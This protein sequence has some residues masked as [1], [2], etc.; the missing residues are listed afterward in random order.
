MVSG[1]EQVAQPVRRR[2]AAFPDVADIQDGSHGTPFVPWV[3]ED[4]EHQKA[5]GIKA[6][7]W[8]PAQSR[9]PNRLQALV[10]RH[11]VQPLG[12]LGNNIGVLDL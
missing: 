8:L 12:L 9:R 11:I 3:R 7:P 10:G 5:H 6:M 2:T 4:V 1:S